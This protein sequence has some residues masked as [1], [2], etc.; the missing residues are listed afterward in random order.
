MLLDLSTIHPTNT[1]QNFLSREVTNGGPTMVESCANRT[2]SYWG[3]Y[4]PKNNTGLHNISPRRGE[5]NG[6]YFYRAAVGV[7]DVHKRGATTGQPSITAT[8]SGAGPFWMDDPITFTA[9]TEFCTPTSDGWDWSDNDTVASTINGSG[10]TV[11]FTFNYC[12]SS[13]CPNRTIDVF[14]TNSACPTATV[15]DD[16]ITVQEPRAQIRSLD[17]TPTGLPPFQYPV[18]TLLGFSAD[19]R[20]QSALFLP[21]DRCATPWAPSPPP[22]TNRPSAGIRAES[23]STRSSPPISRPATPRNGTTSWVWRPSR[24]TGRTRRFPSSR[25]GRRGSRC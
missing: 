25:P 20:R 13:D 10:S 17:V 19:R 21:V 8:A 9:T 2:I 14:A 1:N 4:Y 6:N 11:N 23:S 24:P 7:L 12:P 3:W 16:T 5:F 22:E 15:V 18:C